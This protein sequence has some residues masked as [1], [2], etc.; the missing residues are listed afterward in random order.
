MQRAH[1]RSCAHLAFACTHDEH[2][3]PYLAR[4]IGAGAQA[5]DVDA[6]GEG[7]MTSRWTTAGCLVGRTRGSFDTAEGAVEGARLVGAAE[8]ARAAGTGAAPRSGVG[9]RTTVG[10]DGAGAQLAFCS[11]GTALIEAP[12]AGAGAAEVDAVGAGGS[13]SLA[14]AA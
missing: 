1:G 10:R 13:G 8:G 12:L 4:A 7:G 11:G 6:M 14:S 3:V 5:A 9:A 2:E